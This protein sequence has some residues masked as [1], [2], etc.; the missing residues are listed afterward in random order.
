VAWF[1]AFQSGEP[2][3]LEVGLEH[4]HRYVNRAMELKPDWVMAK[5]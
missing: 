2:D 4:I 3:M 1:K 5:M